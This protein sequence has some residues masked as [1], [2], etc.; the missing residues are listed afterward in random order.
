[1]VA[2]LP[3]DGICDRGEAVNATSSKIT[4]RKSDEAVGVVFM[5]AGTFLSGNFLYLIRYIERNDSFHREQSLH[6]QRCNSVLTDVVGCQSATST[7]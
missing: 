5:V 1:M 7:N 3:I 6:S 4:L 2:L